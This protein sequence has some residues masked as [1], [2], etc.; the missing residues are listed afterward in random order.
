M[1]KIFSRFQNSCKN[2]YDNSIIEIDLNPDA[3]TKKIIIFIHSSCFFVIFAC[4]FQ[5]VLSIFAIITRVVFD[6]DGGRLH[7]SG[8]F[9]AVLHVLSCPLTFFCYFFTKLPSLPCYSS[10]SFVWCSC[11]WNQCQIFLEC[12]QMSSSE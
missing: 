12:M 6:L 8:S 1:I 5:K 9:D 10:S 3:I 2:T 4:G 11:F 7:Y